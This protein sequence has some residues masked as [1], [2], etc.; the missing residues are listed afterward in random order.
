M[1][2][3]DW[4]QATL[5]EEQ[6]AYAA[7]DAYAT[8]EVFEVIN[9]KR[10]LRDLRKVTNET[11][12]A[13]TEVVLLAR[14][15]DVEVGRGT[16]VLP[17]A[18]GRRRHEWRPEYLGAGGEA[19]TRTATRVVVA[20]SAVTAPGAALPYITD[21][22]V[23]TVDDAARLHAQGQPGANHVLWDIGRLR[24][25]EPAGAGADAGAGDEGGGAA[26]VA[27]TDE[28]PVVETRA[29][30][31]ADYPPVVDSW[32]AGEGRDA[33]VARTLE[34]RLPEDFVRVSWG[35]D[36]EDEEGDDEGW[37]GV[38][39]TEGCDAAHGGAVKLDMLHAIQ[40]IIQVL[41]K[42]HGA[43]LYFASRMAEAMMGV[44]QAD[45]EAE[46]QRR[47][48]KGM[49]EAEWE[50]HVDKN[51]TDVA[52]RCRRVVPGPLVLRERL[53][54]LADLFAG[55]HDAETEKP[56]FTSKAW[57]RW[58]SLMLHVE[59]GCLSDP[60][61]EY[62]SLYHVVGR[63]RDGTVILACARGTSDLE[64]IK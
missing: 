25:V 7:L 44:V 39:E 8:L 19:L 20:L 34:E 56:L 50:Q 52:R 49:T 12:V 31:D 30:T 9:R 59:K 33:E 3:S 4:G 35:L 48:A 57:K 28:A 54:R 5:S 47:L 61:P 21:T 26:G 41:S 14:S 37:N 27:A 23:S 55:I 51:Y 16:I 38:W 40:R 64:V 1:R 58:N 46:K 18:S 62:V 42:G 60:P 10:T 53:Q 45:V 17:P 13:G 36:E 63:R 11:A 2:K 43:Y 22:A 6:K 15:T 32:G 29:A 24:L